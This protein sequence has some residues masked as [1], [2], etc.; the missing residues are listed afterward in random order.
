MNALRVKDAIYQE[1]CERVAS[2]IKTAEEAIQSAESSQN[3]DTKSSAGDK[4][5]TGREMLKQE[6]ERNQA[7]LA[8]AVSQSNLLKELDLEQK[9][10]ISLG[11]L[12]ETQQGFF[13][14]AVPLGKISVDGGTEAFVISTTSPVGKLFL[15]KQIGETIEFNGR[16]YKIEN[17]F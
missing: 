1:T 8:E 17:I 13:F 15:G 6:I 11:S 9:I 2:K 4:F 7:L 12:V 5:E 16:N 14:L 10:Q 3:E